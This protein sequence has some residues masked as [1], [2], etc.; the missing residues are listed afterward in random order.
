MRVQREVDSVVDGDTSEVNV[1][2]HKELKFL[3]ACMSVLKHLS[4]RL[5][6]LIETL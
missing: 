1:E 3:D 5:E 2:N 4:I 6:R